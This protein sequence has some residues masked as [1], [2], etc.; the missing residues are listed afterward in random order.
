MSLAYRE[1]G[2]PT[3]KPVVLLHGGA[4]GLSTWDRLTP[5]LTAAGH[6]VIAADLRGHG[7]S[8]RADR[9]PLV[10]YRNDVQALVDDLRV[11]E[12]ALVG[13]SLG[14][15]V[16][17]LVAQ[18]EP[19]RVRRLVL[20]EPPAPPRGEMGPPALSRLRMLLLGLSGVARRR[21]YDPKAVTSAI[22]QLRRPDPGWWDA[23]ELVTAP[24]LVLSGGPASH[25]PP[26][27]TADIATALPHA[28]LNTVG[29]GHRI[30]STRP[31]EFAALVVAFLAE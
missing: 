27:R 9:Y 7:R 23:L 12:F 2:D 5:E 10:D 29:A 11:G 6:R 22:Q 8:P 19:G 30:H 4:S 13:H 1:S 26:E 21:P 15:Y 28:D 18:A 24:T 31:D 16:A 14:A 25:L 3:G 20:E 17:T